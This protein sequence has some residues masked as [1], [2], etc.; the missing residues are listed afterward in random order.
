MHFAVGER[1]TDTATA[2]TSVTTRALGFDVELFTFAEQTGQTLGNS[3]EGSDIEQG[4]HRKRQQHRCDPER[5]LLA[6]FELLDVRSDL[7]GLGL[8][9]DVRDGCGCDRWCGRWRSGWL[10][11]GRGFSRSLGVAGLPRQRRL[12]LF[13]TLQ[14][15]FRDFGHQTSPL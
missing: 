13:R 2:F 4:P 5:H 1:R 11:R 15:M 14:Q 7:D 12:T 6:L 8:G 9:R 3:F 10:D